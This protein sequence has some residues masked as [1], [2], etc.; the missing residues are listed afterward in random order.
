MAVRARAEVE[1]R[2]EMTPQQRSRALIMIDQLWRL[3][4]SSMY[5][6]E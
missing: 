1:V 3:G 2:L 6:V 5:T 4:L